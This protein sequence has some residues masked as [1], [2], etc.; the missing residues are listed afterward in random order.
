MTEG[1]VKIQNLNIWV[2]HNFNKM[3]QYKDTH[4]GGFSNVVRFYADIPGPQFF[5]E[6]APL[7]LWT[8]KL[9]KLI[10][11]HTYTEMYDKT[12]S[13]LHVAGGAIDNHVFNFDRADLH[14]DIEDWPAILGYYKGLPSLPWSA[15][16]LEIPEARLIIVVRPLDEILLDSI[17]YHF[18]A[19]IL[20]G[21]RYSTSSYNKSILAQA[22]VKYSG[23]K[24]PSKLKLDLDL[25]YYKF[26]LKI[27]RFLESHF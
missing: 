24:F 18:V 19:A 3:A 25:F 5:M 13:D 27:L 17:L 1:V 6:M 11:P 12:R 26:L 2:P 16:E 14:N 21:V 20:G 23:V 22:E 9:F 7:Y 4:Y 10:A 15:G 8:N